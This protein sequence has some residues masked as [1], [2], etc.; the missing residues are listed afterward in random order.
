[1]ELCTN[2]YRLAMHVVLVVLLV[3]P[4][5]CNSDD[6]ISEIIEDAC[7]NGR[8]VLT[9]NRTEGVEPSYDGG[10]VEGWFSMARGF[11][12]AVKKENLPFR[13][14]LWRTRIFDPCTP[15]AVL[16]RLTLPNMSVLMQ[17]HLL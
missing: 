15:S 17:I 4:L 9:A 2:I 16:H 8:G 3:S 1:M 6:V 12:N 13:L 14:P 11:V 5:G 10:N 7:L